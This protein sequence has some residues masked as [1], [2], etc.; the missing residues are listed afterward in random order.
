MNC[1]PVGD[2]TWGDVFQSNFPLH[3]AC[4]EGNVSS[5]Y[6]LLQENNRHGVYEEDSRYGWTPLHWAS[7]FG[8]IECLKV[9]ME[10]IKAGP[11]KFGEV[12]TS[13]FYQTPL[14]LAASAG[15]VECMEWL[16]NFGCSI[17]SKDY[18]GET[19]VHKAARAGSVK[20]I[21]LFAAYLDQLSVCNVQGK[22]A[23]DL[24]LMNNFPDCARLIL[25]LMQ[26]NQVSDD[27]MLIDGHNQ[28]SSHNKQ[29]NDFFN[30][31]MDCSDD[32]EKDNLLR[33][34]DAGYHG[35]VDTNN[36][37]FFIRRKRNLDHDEFLNFKRMRSS[38]G[39]NLSLNHITSAVTFNGYPHS[40][41]MS[42]EDLEKNDSH[43]ETERL[44]PF[45]QSS[46][47]CKLEPYQQILAISL[48][49]LNLIK[50]TSR[51]TSFNAFI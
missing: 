17:E 10:C 6:Q 29:C 7:F 40:T 41:F 19:A 26:T 4:K 51:N 9:I 24:A 13:S 1:Y 16:M 47:Q 23:Y 20:C 36:Q 31:G 5:M 37:D 38:E 39:C 50:S 12:K 34:S 45:D 14:H 21:R 35:N 27:S 25:E 3:K 43:A 49:P 33:S 30:D 2:F 44:S 22:T 15:Q 8:Q 28:N 46:Q 42:P 18:M 48:E 32:L 11:M